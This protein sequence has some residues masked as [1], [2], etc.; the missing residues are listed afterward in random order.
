M[1]C[2]RFA[3]AAYKSWAGKGGVAS[4]KRWPAVGKA[5]STAHF[6]FSSDP[7]RAPVDAS[8]HAPRSGYPS[9]TGC[10]PCRGCQGFHSAALPATA[11]RHAGAG[12]RQRCA[13]PRL[14]LPHLRLRLVVV[15]HPRSLA[16]HTRSAPATCAEKLPFD[17]CGNGASRTGM[18]LGTRPSP[19]GPSPPHPANHSMACAFPKVKKPR[20]SAPGIGCSVLVPPS[21]GRGAGGA[22]EAR[23]QKLRPG[24]GAGRCKPVEGARLDAI[25][26]LAISRHFARLRQGWAVDPARVWSLPGG[27]ARPGGPGGA[28]TGSDRARGRPGRTS[29]ALGGSRSEKSK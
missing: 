25:S 14:R 26:R 8:R 2:S 28:M 3:V 15:Q 27:P 5:A 6:V 16:R 20:R 29:R 12:G 11:V 9:I 22:G 1:R 4:W 13:V 18:S 17:A 10:L 19:S 23:R 7:I 21:V 24:G